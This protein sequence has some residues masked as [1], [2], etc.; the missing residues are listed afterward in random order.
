MKQKVTIIEIMILLVMIFSNCTQQSGFPVLKGPYLGQKPPGDV[1]ELF[2]PAIVSSRFHEHSFPAFSP[3]YREVYWTIGFPGQRSFQPRMLTMKR[4]AGRW[5]PP[6][7][8]EFCRD[9]IDAELSFSPDGNRIFFAS[10][11]PDTKDGLPRPDWDIWVVDRTSDGWSEPNHLGAPICTD[12]WEQ[13]P[14]VANNGTLYYNGYWEDG[15]NK[16][17]IYRSEIKNGNYSDPELLPE[18]IN[19]P[20]VDWTPFIASDES[21]LLWS[22]VRSGGYGSGDLYISFRG[23]DGSWT[24]AINLGPRINTKYN[25]R[26]PYISPDGKYLFFLSNHFNYESENMAKLSYEQ[27]LAMCDGPGN[28]YC[29]IYWV[30]AKIIEKLKPKN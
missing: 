2:A 17:G 30:D 4:K 15:R 16:Y 5:S 18:T 26:Y 9:F 20:H 6:Q 10:N 23:K 12:K 8:A 1:P 14:T 27:I 22:S 24:E 7:L 13:Q 25:E 29:D 21:F 3:D 28:G 11:R 19:S